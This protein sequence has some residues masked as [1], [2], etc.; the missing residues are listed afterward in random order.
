MLPHP[1]I[2]AI[3][4][5]ETVQLEPAGV[6][7]GYD[8]GYPEVSLCPLYSGDGLEVGIWECKPGGW[9]IEDRPSTEICYVISGSGMVTDADGGVR[10]LG[11]GTVLTLPKGWSGRWDITATLRKVYVFTL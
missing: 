3:S 11:P 2:A 1:A 4:A 8:S 6:R 10:A 5:P 9:A 7:S